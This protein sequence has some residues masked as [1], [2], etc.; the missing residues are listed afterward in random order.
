PVQLGG[1]VRD[2]RVQVGVVGRGA[3][4]LPGRVHQVDHLV[5]AGGGGSVSRVQRRGGRVLQCNAAVD[6]RVEDVD[7]V[8]RQRHLAVDRGV[9]GVD[10]LVRLRDVEVAQ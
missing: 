4:Q 6:V 10:D 3:V 5:A 9:E 2:L 7:V 8:L 1:G